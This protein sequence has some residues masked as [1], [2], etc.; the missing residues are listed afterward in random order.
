MQNDV[1]ESKIDAMRNEIYQNIQELR[2]SQNAMTLDESRND[3]LSSLHN[4]DTGSVYIRWGSQECPDTADLVYTGHTASSSWDHIG[5]GSNYICL[6]DDSEYDDTKINP[7]IQNSR[8]FLF[9]VEYRPFEF[10]SLKEQEYNNAACAVCR[11]NRN[12]MLMI[13][14]KLT[15]PMG[16]SREYVGYL[17][18]SSYDFKKSE[19]ICVDQSLASPFG[20]QV[21]R[22]QGSGLFL[23][24]T[25]CLDP[26]PNHYYGALPCNQYPS[27]HELPCVVCT[28]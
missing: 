9:S 18:S 1:M 8:G 10:P 24:E 6:P 7:D 12:T 5:G 22:Q 16:W 28:M 13:P 15:C 19:F 14:A 25:V 26:D 4:S 3:D 17:M 21:Y 11:A 27:G 20:Q 23:V 2:I